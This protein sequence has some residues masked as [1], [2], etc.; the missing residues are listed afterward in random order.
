MNGPFARPPPF[1]SRTHARTHARTLAAA[2]AVFAAG[3]ER[4]G[5][6]AA[7][8]EGWSGGG[9]SIA[10]ERETKA[11]R[12]HRP[13]GARA[14]AGGG[15]RRR[16]R[17]STGPPRACIGPWHELRHRPKVG[18]I[19]AGCTS[20]PWLERAARRVCYEKASHGSVVL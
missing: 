4:I 10:R 9:S 17:A 11:A 15:K 18:Y 13:I 7:G 16:R 2:R 1:A 3:G 6:T 12:H 20:A 5:V 19:A 8:P 14:V